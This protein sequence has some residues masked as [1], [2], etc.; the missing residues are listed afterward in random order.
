VFKSGSLQANE[1]EEWSQVFV[2]NIHTFVFGNIFDL[3]QT[4]LI[5]KRKLRQAHKNF[6]FYDN[7]TAVRNDCSIV[8]E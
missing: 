5:L 1:D 2:I 7:T 3:R 8:Y 4:I 6:G